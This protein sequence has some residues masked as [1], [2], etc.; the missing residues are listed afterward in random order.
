[1][2]DQTKPAD[3]K[4]LDRMLDIFGRAFHCEVGDMSLAEARAAIHEAFNRRCAPDASGEPSPHH[5]AQLLCKVAREHRDGL[6]IDRAREIATAWLSGDHTYFTGSPNFVR[7]VQSAAPNPAIDFAISV[8]DNV[9]T[10]IEDWEDKALAEAV[11]EAK[12][13]LAHLRLRC[14]SAAPAPEA[15]YLNSLID[16]LLMPPNAMTETNLRKLHGEA[17]EMLGLQSN[18]LICTLSRPAPEAAEGASDLSWDAREKAI[19]QAMAAPEAGPQPTDDALM[20]QALEAIEAFPGKH[21]SDDGMLR[22]VRAGMAARNALR[23]RLASPP[24]PLVLLTNGLIAATAFG[25]KREVLALFDT[26]E[27]AHAFV[28]QLQP[29]M[30]LQG[31]ATLQGGDGIV[32]GKDAK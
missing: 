23:S 13:K 17:A 8:F 28:R 18:L 2:T 31:H 22:F 10:D 29:L 4:E 12:E 20:R 27:Q 7:V 30:K 6:A 9:L 3:A 32:A 5:I 21:A 11:T 24:Q 15:F 1:M 16:R 19:A 14:E 26:A 25:Q